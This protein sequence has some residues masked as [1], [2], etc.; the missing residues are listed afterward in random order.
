[1]LIQ[2]ILEEVMIG[3]RLWKYDF[4]KLSTTMTKKEDPKILFWIWAYFS[5]EIV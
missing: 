4:W 1:V 5:K 3:I 2:K